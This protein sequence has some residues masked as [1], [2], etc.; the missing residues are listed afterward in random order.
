MWFG[1]IWQWTRLS[2]SSRYVGKTEPVA[3]LASSGTATLR[4]ADQL[5]VCLRDCAPAVTRL[6]CLALPLVSFRK[7]RVVQQLAWRHSAF[8]LLTC[9]C[10]CLHRS[11]LWTDT[12]NLCL[13]VQLAYLEVT[14]QEKL[15]SGWPGPL[16]KVEGCCDYS[17]VCFQ[18]EQTSQVQL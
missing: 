5:S 12:W 8:G 16:A 2:A 4:L 13:C 6:P 3:E 7:F 9:V 14:V 18:S 15:G 17:F 1:F 10:P 11:R